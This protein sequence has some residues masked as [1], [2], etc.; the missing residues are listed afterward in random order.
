[1]TTDPI[2]GNA[3]DVK[4][5]SKIKNKKTKKKTKNKGMAF[6]LI[7][8]QIYQT[9]GIWLFIA[10]WIAVDTSFGLTS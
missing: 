6:G 3:F 4:Q 8:L 10:L 9:E 5:K 7:R 2:S 1:M